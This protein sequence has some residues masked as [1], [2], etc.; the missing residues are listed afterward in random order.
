MRKLT[1]IALS[2]AALAAVVPRSSRTRMGGD[3]EVKGKVKVK[4]GEW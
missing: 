2:T 4:G 3:S 1:N